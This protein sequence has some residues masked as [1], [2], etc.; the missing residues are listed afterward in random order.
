MRRLQ[1]EHHI[2][3]QN[4]E[5]VYKTTVEISSDIWKLKNPAKD[6]LADRLREPSDFSPNRDEWWFER[7]MDMHRLLQV[8]MNTLAARKTSSGDE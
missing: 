1:R 3:L 7:R 8:E 6:F 4:D 5:Y 2:D